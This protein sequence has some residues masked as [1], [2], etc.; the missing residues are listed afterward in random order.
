MGKKHIRAIIW[1]MGA[2]GLI[3]GAFLFA[4]DRLIK[5]A[6]TGRISGEENAVVPHC[7]AGLVLGCNRYVKDGRRNLYFLARMDAAA[8]L[9]KN[10]KVDAL[11]VSGDN[12]IASYDEP[13]DMKT[14]LTTK[15]VPAEKI[16]CDYAGFRT[17]D[18]VIRAKTIFLQDRIIIVSQ[19]FHVRRAIYIARHHGIDAYG[20]AARDVEGVHSI[21]INLR[22]LAAKGKAVLDVW[23]GKQPKFAGPP[24]RIP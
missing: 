20:Y 12:H 7:T 5:A 6:S 14:A 16:F 22:E 1:I 23:S 9:F 18:S 13:S 15:G 8:E 3:G 4:S 2:A 11:I 24:I 17:L 19:P 10:G 21:R